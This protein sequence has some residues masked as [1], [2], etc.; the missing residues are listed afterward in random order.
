MNSRD[1]SA[2]LAEQVQAAAASG[3][4]LSLQGGNSKSFMRTNAAADTLLS[5]QEH[6]G[7]VRYQPVE[8]VITA[9]AGTPLTELNEVLASRGQMLPFEPPHF[10]PTA[11]LG[12]TVATAQ[13]GPGRAYYGAA[14][15]FLLGCRFINGRGETLRVGGEVMKNVAGFDL[16]RLMCGAYGSLGV[17]LEL[18][19]KVL[20][21]PEC[22]RTLL[23]EHTEADALALCQ[24]LRRRAAP[25]TASFYHQGCLY[26]RLSGTE[27]AVS[28]AAST[29]GGQMLAADGDIWRLVREQQLAC[30][31]AAQSLWRLSLPVTCAPYPEPTLWE[32]NGSQRWLFAPSD[33]S[34]PE[35]W[36][37]E[38][39]GSAT[40][41]RNRSERDLP[42][43][44]ALEPKLADLHQRIKRALDPFGVLPPCPY[45]PA[46]PVVHAD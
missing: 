12:G 6:R 24:Q 37:R 35:R 32:W 42:R 22:N 33:S 15:D 36:A 21:R 39:G 29:L 23:L 46:E 13:S 2:V 14:R 17:L 20:P 41:F 30:F 28:A 31:N 43:F 1:L 45:L 3:S 10:G 9:R 25:A 19:F 26:L 44:P 27:A 5:L 18:S 38:H 7:V 8:L 4:R 34:G 40:L 11:T 16:A